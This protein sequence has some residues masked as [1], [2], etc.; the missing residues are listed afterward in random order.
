[1]AKPTQKVANPTFG[2]FAFDLRRSPVPVYAATLFVSAVLLFWVQPLVA[3]LMLP[4]LGGASAVWNTAMMFFQ[5]MLLAGYF[6]AH[7]L[8]RRVPAA[9]QPWVHAAVVLSAFAVLPI[10]IGNAV[11]PVNGTPV[12]WLLKRLFV[13]IGLPFFALS[14]SAP[15]LQ[16]WFAR[17]GDASAK[18][19]YFLYSASNLGSLL[20]LLG[21]PLV[22]EPWLTLGTQTRLWL[23]LYGLLVVLL[24][25]CALR[26]QAAGWREEAD[27]SE[28]SQTAVSI[29]LRERALWVALAFAPS[30]LLLGVTSF[31]T[32]D[33]ASAPLLWI[34]PLALYLLSF[35]ITFARRPIVSPSWSLLAH[36]VS[37][38]FLALLFL[39][40][41]VS[42]GAA[43]AGH[44]I[45]F[46][47]TALLCHGALAARRPAAARLTD[48]YFCLSLGGAL[49]GVFNALLAP[50]LFSSAY[51][52]PL[53]LILACL[54]RLPA[55]G[56]P[57]GLNRRDILFPAAL[58]AAVI[59]LI[60][61]WSPLAAAGHGLLLVA[62]LAVPVSVFCLS[63]RAL[64][65]ALAVAAVLVPVTVAR[66]TIGILDQERSFFGIYR[67][68]VDPVSPMLDMLHGTVLHGAEFI[69]PA[70]WRDEVRYY[71]DVGPLG[72]FFDALRAARQT[73][74]KIGVT[75]LGTGALACYGRPDE[76][77]TFFEI[78]PVVV[79]IAR[80]TRFFHYLDLCGKR[81]R[82]VLGDARLSLKAEPAHRY[83]VLILDAFSSDAIP[84]HLLTRE[85][86]QLYLDKL[87]EHGVILVHISNQHL[88]LSP[89][90]AAMASELGLAQR[91]Q[92]FLPSPAQSGTAIGSEWMIL[93]RHN[94]DL[95]FLDRAPAWKP[96][97]PGRALTPWTDDFSNILSVLRW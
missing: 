68:K 74:Q 32:V 69:A 19:P 24:G 47:I 65:F 48:F 96:Y 75:G 6:Y 95:G 5:A 49:G 64:R 27:A 77:W 85:A 25:V 57:L 43:M 29:T 63:T 7:L 31:I 76:A 71:A 90:V 11:P 73:P 66:S 61:Y 62:V 10:A 93:A 87:G 91:H 22:L 12:F 36:A 45:A 23:V 41:T 58:C 59:A 33:I 54:L 13:C 37:M 26:S 78:D 60:R 2:E 38:A 30:S 89:E 79:R 80:D 81:A 97:V 20:A 16:S 18:D 86:F 51:E 8:S 35:V 83:D 21:F 82:I 67:V 3:K 1:M 28:A 92:L 44:Y 34:I 53:V 56:R 39:L 52:Y 15:L 88:E 70:H 50:V 17:S 42:L 9:K 72:Q 4:L 94:S 55:L 40:P 46:F 14:S 84:I